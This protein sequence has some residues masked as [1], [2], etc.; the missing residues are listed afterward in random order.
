[1]FLVSSSSRPEF[2]KFVSD[3]MHSG[4]DEAVKVHYRY[5]NVNALEEA[6]LAQL[7]RTKK[8]RNAQ[9]ADSKESAP[10]EGETT[11]RLVERR[12]VPPAQP[13]LDN[14]RPVIRG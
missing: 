1:D 10:S 14:G 11:G 9:L 4:W 6:W 3:G 12:T 13:L 7:R 2:L 8:Q 5:D